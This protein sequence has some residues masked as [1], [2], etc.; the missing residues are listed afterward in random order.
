MRISIARETSEGEKRV[1][2]MPPEVAKLVQGRHEIY[3]EKNAGFSINVFDR[4]YEK[5]GAK[6]LVDREQLFRESDLLVKLKAPTSEEFN[7][8]GDN[9]LFSMLHHA[10]NPQN[11]YLL[12]KNNTKAIEVESIF[13]DAGERLIDQTDITGETGVLYA[14]HH[15]QKIPQEAKALIL[16]YGRV[17][18]GAI[19]MCSKLGINFKIL[20]KT[21][22]PDIKH[23]LKDRDLLI[24][25][26]S[27]PKEEREGKNYVVSRD[28]L[29]LLNPGA[30]ILDL[31]VDF[32]NPIE[33]VR[34]TSLSNPYYI[35]E[36]KVHIGIYGYPGLVPFS[37]SRRYS[38]QVL[39]LVM[40]IAENGGLK[41]LAERGNLGRHM[42]R[43]IVD[44]KKLG[45]ESLKPEEKEES[46]IE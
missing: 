12:G 44:P 37:S 41:N 9:I 7:L 10:Q 43:A 4:A 30:V 36:G 26:I 31:S 25:A 24:N 46:L 17:G 40:E 14:V 39:P 21:E 34:P 20:R 32:P 29:S 27:W 8:L 11:V 15:L 23:F 16:G 28:M 19:N 2:L 45:W 38:A 42:S 1:F 5:A 13:N 22:Y 3:V 6:I 18:S 35:E 33:T